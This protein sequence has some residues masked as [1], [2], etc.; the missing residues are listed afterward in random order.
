[1]KTQLIIMLERNQLVEMI[2]MAKNGE[3]SKRRIKVLKVIDDQ[4]T[5]FC[6]TKFS[7]RTFIIEN[8]LAIMPIPK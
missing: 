7:P 1:M 4:F 5:A 8:V 3:I 2:Y 6:F